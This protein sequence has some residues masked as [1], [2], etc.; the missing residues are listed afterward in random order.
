MNQIRK[1]FAGPGYS[2]LR[3]LLLFTFMICLCVKQ[4]HYAFCQIIVF[5]IVFFDA[6]TR[7]LMQAIKKPP[8]VVF[9]TGFVNDEVAFVAGLTGF[10]SAAKD[11]LI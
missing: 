4:C 10:P 1:S 6:G 9:L 11:T 7:L 3:V 8:S 5:F 2:G